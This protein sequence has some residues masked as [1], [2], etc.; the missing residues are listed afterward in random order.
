M[1]NTEYR[2]VVTRRGG[3]SFA[4]DYSITFVSF[5]FDYSIAFILAVS[6]VRCFAFSKGT[7]PGVSYLQ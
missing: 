7:L 6:W 5:A 4:F 1:C 3:V 2:I